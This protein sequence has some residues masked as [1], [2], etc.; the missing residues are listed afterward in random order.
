MI[1][2]MD[3]TID[4]PTA[5]AT[6]SSA[7]ETPTDFDADDVPPSQLTLGSMQHCFFYMR[8]DAESLH[9]YGMGCRLTKDHFVR[10]VHGV[11]FE[12]LREMRDLGF[13]FEIVQLSEILHK[14]GLL[15]GIGGAYV[16]F[17]FYFFVATVAS[18]ECQLS[19]PEHRDALLAV[20]DQ[21]ANR[22]N[23][24]LAGPGARHGE[25]TTQELE[26]RDA[27]AEVLERFKKHLADERK[28]HGPDP[29][30]SPEETAELPAS[31]EVQA[32]DT[33]IQG[34]NARTSQSTTP[35]HHNTTPP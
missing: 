22:T 25:P 32:D 26:L 31:P 33:T 20:I 7:Q 5:L 1:R 17:T 34:F 3:Q 19:Q 11:L 6:S 10:P 14:H 8:M 12:K 21:C 13:E 15:D 9:G 35:Q 30:K 16:V 29:A 18:L 4:T 2:F 27:V 28:A 23:N 24:S